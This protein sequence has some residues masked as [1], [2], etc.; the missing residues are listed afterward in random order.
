MLPSDRI[1]ALRC[2]WSKTLFN[3]PLPC[4]AVPAPFPPLF[5]IPNPTPLNLL[6][7]SAQ[8]PWPPSTPPRWS[9]STSSGIASPPRTSPRCLP[10][11]LLPLNIPSRR[12]ARVLKWRWVFPPVSGLPDFAARGG[13]WGDHRGGE[14]AKREG[15][16]AGGAAHPQVLPE[17]PRPC[18]ARHGGHVRPRRDGRAPGPFRA[19]VIYLFELCNLY[20]YFVGLILFLDALVQYE[21]AWKAIT[22]A[23]NVLNWSALSVCAVGN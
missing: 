12:I 22:I 21:L 9:A 8:L 17:L 20:G 10:L 7:P 1:A 4:S 11:P 15:Q 6:L 3:L 16:A 2:V 23:A 5:L 19:L 18:H 13:L 14:G